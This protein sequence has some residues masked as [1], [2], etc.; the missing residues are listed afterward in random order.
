MEFNTY[1]QVSA[2]YAEGKRDGM[3]EE[4]ARNIKQQEQRDIETY[5]RF[6]EMIEGMY[7]TRHLDGGIEEEI[8]HGKSKAS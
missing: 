8:P 2:A 1:R 5:T 3:E 4:R 6:V 7:S